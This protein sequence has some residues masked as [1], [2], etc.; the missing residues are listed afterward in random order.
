MCEKKNKIVMCTLSASILFIKYFGMNMFI[1][2][3]FLLVV[4]F[5]SEKKIEIRSSY[6]YFLGNISQDML[7]K[8]RETNSALICRLEKDH[9]CMFHLGNHSLYIVGKK[10]YFLC[11]FSLHC[12]CF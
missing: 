3:N 11:F 5:L 6:A 12:C 10:F 1:Y 4:L 9:K 8:L 7:R 2:G